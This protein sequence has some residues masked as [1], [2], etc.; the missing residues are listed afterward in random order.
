MHYMR[1][2]LQTSCEDLIGRL[3]MQ[4]DNTVEKTVDA[5]DL[6]VLN[7]MIEKRTTYRNFLDNLS[8]RGGPP[9][10][11]NLAQEILTVALDCYL[12]SR[13]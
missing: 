13:K 11:R 8:D 10:D 6:I 1:E 9:L 12:E 3:T 4:I 5:A 7:G 2:A